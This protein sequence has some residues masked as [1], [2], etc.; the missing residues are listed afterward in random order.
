MGKIYSVFY[1]Y[2]PPF[3]LQLIFRETILNHSCLEH[4]YSSRVFTIMNRAILEA[5]G[6]SMAMMILSGIKLRSNINNIRIIKPL[7]LS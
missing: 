3:S 4:N 5:N 7:N 6:V 1:Y 2:L